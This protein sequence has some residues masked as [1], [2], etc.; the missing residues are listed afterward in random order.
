MNRFVIYISVSISMV[1]AGA[2]WAGQEKS[3]PQLRLELDLVDGSRVI[4]TPSVASVPMRTSY[5]RVDIPLNQILTMRVGSDHETASFDLQNGDQL[6]GVITLEPVKLETVFGSVAIGIE[7]IREI[8]VRLGGGMLPDVFKRDLI[9]YYSFDRDENGRVTDESGKNNSGVVTGAKWTPSG[10]VN[11]AYYFSG[12]ADHI[13]V[14]SQALRKSSSDSF[15]VSVWFYAERLNPNDENTV[16]GISAARGV[17]DGAFSYRIGIGRPNGQGADFAVGF[18]AATWCRDNSVSPFMTGLA[19]KQ[20]Y[21]AV[22]VYDRGDIRLYVNGE[23]KGRTKYS[24]G[25]AGPSDGDD[26][27]RYTSSSEMSSMPRSSSRAYSSLKGLPYLGGSRG[28]TPA[29]TAL[30]GCVGNCVG[31]FESRGFN[32]TIDELMFFDRA[33]SVED[34]KQLYDVQ[35]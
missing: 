22:G 31:L 11:G 20:W 33:L 10:K 1:F 7:H 27:A 16:F 12:V 18:T 14:D 21:H 26:R 3:E 13:I 4:G 23:E 24:L 25:S 29:S 34:V 2:L 17:N 32:G 28:T 9:L 35:R 15:S 5:A 6:K 8:R 30:M 19:E